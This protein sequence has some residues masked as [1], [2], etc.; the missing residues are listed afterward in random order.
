MV[1]GVGVDGE[2]RREDV[3]GADGLEGVGRRREVGRGRADG[4]VEADDDGGCWP[5]VG[6]GADGGEEVRFLGLEVRDETFARPQG[7]AFAGDAR[8]LGV[9]SG[10]G[11]GELVDEHVERAAHRGVVASEVLSRAGVVE[12]R[13]EEQVV[14]RVLRS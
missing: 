10:D 14:H 4:G 5:A 3:G 13:G 1:E 6:D 11:A 7:E 9:G 8:E 12:V 2:E